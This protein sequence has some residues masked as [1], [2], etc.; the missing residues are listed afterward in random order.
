MTKP[1]KMLVLQLIIVTMT[2]SLK[3]NEKKQKKKLLDTNCTIR[4]SGC[5]IEVKDQEH[6][7]ARG[8]SSWVFVGFLRVLQFP[9]TVQQ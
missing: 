5:T 8:K 2:A 7:V 6:L 9:P 4:L 1:E 3:R